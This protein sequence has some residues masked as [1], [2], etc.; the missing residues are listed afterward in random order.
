MHSKLLISQEVSVEYSVRKWNVS[1]ILTLLHRQHFFYICFSDITGNHSFRLLHNLL[2]IWIPHCSTC[3][4][5]QNKCTQCNDILSWKAMN[6]VWWTQSQ[7][8]SWKCWSK[9]IS[10]MSQSFLSSAAYNS[11]TFSYLALKV[12]MWSC[13]FGRPGSAELK[14]HP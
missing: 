5:E 12:W 9:K 6:G 3:L 10:D 8:I 1:A 2:L 13:G 7:S 14:L 11:T 4:M